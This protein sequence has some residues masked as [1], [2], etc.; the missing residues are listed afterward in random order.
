MPSL[1]KMNSREET[2]IPGGKIRLK[3][4]HVNVNCRDNTSG[5]SPLII[6]VLNGKA[7]S[8]IK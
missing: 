7:H 1:K 6:A 8:K 5:Y 4:T 2:N 3:L